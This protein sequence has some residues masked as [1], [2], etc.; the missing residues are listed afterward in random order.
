MTFKKKEKI[1]SENFW[2]DLMSNKINLKEILLF[3]DELE[4]CEKSIKI[5]NEL[6]S[7]LEKQNKI[8][9]F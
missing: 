2:N 5:L 9:Y 3:E 7:E 4:D 6:K 8:I 1:H